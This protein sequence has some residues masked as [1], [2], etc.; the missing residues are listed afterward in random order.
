MKIK[1]TRQITKNRAQDFVTKL[2]GEVYIIGRNKYGVST[3]SW[4][5][6][7]DIT[8][9]GY[10]D[11][12]TTD[13]T[14]GGLPIL[15]SNL[16]FSKDAIINCVLEGRAIDVRDFIEKL[17]PSA[18][19]DYIALQFAFEEKLIPVDFLNNTDSIL[20]ER[21]AYE[22]VFSLLTDEQSKVEFE[23]LLN[24]R[25]NRDIQFQK[26][27]RFRINE[28]YFED[29]VILPQKATF[30]DGGGFDG[31]TTSEFVQKHRDYNSV[32]YFEPTESSMIASK[33]KL[34]VNNNINFFQ[35][36]LWSQATTLHFDTS[37]GSAN[38]I[39]NTGSVSIETVS[40]DEVVDGK[41]DFI[42]LDI[43]G[44]EIEAING[45]IATIKKFKPKM[46]VCIYH[47]QSDFIE[48][49]KLALKLNPGYKI[50]VRHYTQG[51]FETVMYFV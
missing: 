17:R 15:K 45:A 9:V 1:D 32:Y 38:K 21:E 34:R 24:F 25:L 7:K 14:Y 42:K 27:F 20:V 16:D 18:S 2:S 43:E 40:I 47:N 4:L 35:K 12:Y 28:Q 23:A 5:T 10:I 13:T 30:V 50:Y 33:N 3:T 29:F 41:V 44:A 31:A 36:G 46:A 51:V 39:A 8:V 48:I 26:D 19:M 6:K 22:N 49:P 37:L 11:D